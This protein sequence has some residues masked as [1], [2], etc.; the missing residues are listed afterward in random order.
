MA[1]LEEQIEFVLG[2]DI[3]A[4]YQNDLTYILTSVLKEVISRIE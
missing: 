4:S 3:G 2:K 1:T